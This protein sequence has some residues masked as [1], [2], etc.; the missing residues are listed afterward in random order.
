MT[1]SVKTLYDKNYDFDDEDKLV[2]KVLSSEELMPNIGVE[3]DGK[4]FVKSS[5]KNDNFNEKLFSLGSLFLYGIPVSTSI[6]IPDW[7][8]WRE[9]RIRIRKKGILPFEITIV[10]EGRNVEIAPILIKDNI[11]T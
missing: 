1:I 2:K 8:L 4:W 3:V 6:E 7:C 5:A 11:V 9:A 10:L